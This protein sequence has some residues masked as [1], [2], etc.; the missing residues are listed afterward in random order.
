MTG[1]DYQKQAMRTNDGKCVNRMID[2]IMKYHKFNPDIPGMDKIT[3]LDFGGIL[4]ACIGLSGEVGEINE[5]IK[6]WV[7]HERSFELDQ[8]KKEIGDVMWYIALICDSFH[9]GL[10]EIFEINLDKLYKRYPD[11]FDTYRANHH[12]PD[13]I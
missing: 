4:C 9:F 11:G 3:P 13:D 2:K 8:L 1:N 5:I 10:D 12:E 6:K 7:F